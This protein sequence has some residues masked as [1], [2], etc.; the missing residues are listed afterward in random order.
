M[1]N[2]IR[3]SPERFEARSIVQELDFFKN[4]CADLEVE[5]KLLHE[6]AQQ[7]QK[8]A[9]EVITSDHNVEAFLKENGMLQNENEKL[10]KLSR[11]RKTDADLWKSKYENQMQQ[12]LQIRSNYE[13]EIKQLT[14]ELQKLTAL[15]QQ[16]DA[17]RQRQLVGLT[18]QIE[19]QSN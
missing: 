17:E 18:G 14:A 7:V 11:Q 5:N 6:E 8:R 19:S 10:I 1:Y 15:M 9:H 2:S 16:N 4:R 13:F 12:I 3:H